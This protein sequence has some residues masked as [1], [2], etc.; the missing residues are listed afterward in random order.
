[1]MPR[2]V[3]ATWPFFVPHYPAYSETTTTTTTTQPKTVVA[4][5]KVEADCVAKKEILLANGKKLSSEE[6][7]RKIREQI[8]MNRHLLVELKEKT[9]AHEA[10]KIVH[11]TCEHCHHHEP[12]RRRSVSPRSTT[13]RH[14][15]GE[16]IG[17][18]LRSENPHCNKYYEA[19]RQQMHDLYHQCE[20]RERDAAPET[21]CHNHKRSK[22]VSFCHS[23]DEV[24]CC[25]HAWKDGTELSFEAETKKTKKSSKPTYSSI[26]TFFL[27]Y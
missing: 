14:C 9:Q 1:M 26:Y 16:N 8:E 22:S 5:S 18:E 15:S 21:W 13:V 27:S 19:Y 12:R 7:D 24:L 23:D 20:A 6:L 25:H 3:Y 4:S 17:E 2:L 10:A 11:C